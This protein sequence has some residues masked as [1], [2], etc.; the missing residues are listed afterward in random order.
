MTYWYFKRNAVYHRCSAEVCYRSIYLSNGKCIGKRCNVYI[1]PNILTV[2]FNYED[3]Y[4]ILEPERHSR[5]IYMPFHP[6]KELN[7]TDLIKELQC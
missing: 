6:D 7:I 2:I 5:W 3:S 4:G 1:N